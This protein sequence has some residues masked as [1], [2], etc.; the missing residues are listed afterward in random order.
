M[1]ANSNYDISN[2]TNLQKKASDIVEYRSFEDMGLKDLL[3]RGIYSNSF[4]KPTDIQTKAIVPMIKRGDVIIQAQSGTGKTG[5]FGIGLL[6]KV[7]FENKKPQILVLSPTRE[8]AVQTYEVI[9][10][11]GTYLAEESNP[12]FCQTF[13]GGTNVRNDIKKLK[14]G[15][16]VLVGTPGRVLD[17]AKQGSYCTDGMVTIVLD[18][19]D[20][21]LSQGFQEQIYEIFRFMPNTVQICLVS[22]TMPKDVLELS[23]KFLHNP[24]RILVETEKLTLEGIE[25][26]YIALNENSKLDALGDLYK[27]ISNAQ[28]IVFVNTRRKADFITEELT[29]KNHSVALI[30]SDLP[31]GEREKIMR[32]FRDGHHRVLITTDLFCRGIDVQHVNIVVNAD[33]PSNMENYLHRIGRSGRF[34]RKG[35][36]INF[37]TERDIENLKNIEKH[38]NI[39]ITELKNNFNDYF[40]S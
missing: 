13:V 27:S 18:E 4:E 24:T 32:Q 14:D 37:V 35:M 36:A 23:E 11:F 21:M 25:Q 22:A 9:N 6:E 12:S 40:N 26:H 7:N 19:A 28:A 17:L 1:I 30:H 33:L 3:L 34:G 2:E 5:A 39:T 15:A 38:Y 20:E 8:L 10:K 16:I 29:K 31:K